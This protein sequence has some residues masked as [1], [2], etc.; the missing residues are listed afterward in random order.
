MMMMKP[1][2]APSNKAPGKGGNEEQRERTQVQARR[3]KPKVGS[4]GHR[5]INYVPPLKY[6]WLLC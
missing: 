5:N 2:Q 6:Y 4:K 1:W 3:A